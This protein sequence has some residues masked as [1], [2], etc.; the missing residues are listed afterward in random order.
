MK[1]LFF[2]ASILLTFLVSCSKEENPV[3]PISSGV[4]FYLGKIGTERIYDQT[5]KWFVPNTDS[6]YI[7]IPDS[8]RSQVPFSN[9][10]LE[11]G[12]VSKSRITQRIDS[13]D[14]LYYAYWNLPYPYTEYKSLRGDG[15]GFDLSEFMLAV[16]TGRSYTG[17]FPGIDW[18]TYIETDDSVTSISYPYGTGTELLKPLKI[19][20]EW[21][22][23]EWEYFDSTT[24]TI[25]TH[26][27][28]AKV[29]DEVNV[30]VKAGSF[31]AYKIE[32]NYNWPDLNYTVLFKYE[33]YVPNIGLVLEEW[34]RIIYAAYFDQ[35]GTHTIRVREVGRNELVSYNILH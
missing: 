6:P 27:I 30:V 5:E 29:I 32:V 17:S 33:Y 19:N 18:G 22:R 3:N 21:I 31:K 23:N 8:L 13:I 4:P 1:Y 7:H 14:L 11:Q 25:R 9:E 2:I 28:S 26:N 35:S 24:V 20:L 10:E 16:S 15:E 34:D 12:L